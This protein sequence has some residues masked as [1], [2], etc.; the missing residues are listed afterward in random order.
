M[1]SKRKPYNDVYGYVASR[2][3]Y[4]GC[5]GYIVIYDRENG[6][7]IDADERWIVMHEPSSLH[8]AVPTRA[9]AYKDMKLAAK[10][11]LPEIL[12]SSNAE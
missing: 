2:K 5:G 6:F 7:D 11:L 12:P 10:G 8:V 1:G 3:C 9:G 4:A